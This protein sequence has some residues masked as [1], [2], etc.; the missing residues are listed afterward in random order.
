MNKSTHRTQ[1]SAKACV[2][3]IRTL[4]LYSK[5]RNHTIIGKSDNLEFGYRFCPCSDL[6]HSQT[7]M[8]SEVDHFIS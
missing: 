5:N 7:L 2:V 3:Y 8:G 1:T 6:D 4:T